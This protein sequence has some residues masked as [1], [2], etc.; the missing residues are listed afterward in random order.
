MKRE[1]FFDNAKFIVITLVVFGHVIQ[2]LTVDSTAMRTLYEWIYL[3]HMPAIILVSGFF[4]KGHYSWKYLWA[5][6]RK[7]LIPYLLFQKVYTSYFYFTTSAG[8]DTPMF[9]PH[10][11]LWF[12]LSLFSWHIL[13]IGFKHIPARF[14]IPLAFV[15]GILIGYVD[16]IGHTYSL[17]RT[18]VFFPFFLIGYWLTKDQLFLVKTTIAR[19][20]SLGL[21]VLA[22]VL[23][24]L[25]PEIPVGWL[26]G[27]S[28]YAALDVG[29][30]GGIIRVIQY[31]VML[32]MVFSLYAW[33][34][35]KQF[36]WTNLG[37]QTI[38]VYLLHGLFVQFF[39]QYEVLQ[40]NTFF[41]L[42]IIVAISLGIVLLLSSKPI[43]ISF[44]PIIETKTTAI[45]AH[46]EQINS[47]RA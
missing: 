22:F 26:F 18:F 35:R 11:S 7:L 23:V 3:F 15:M 38:Y 9:E 2:P 32:V 30:S 25:L 21:F 5:L 10:W 12:L 14:G 24:Y 8:W 19:R 29:L 44:Q 6:S 46:M 42:V 45:K 37:E 27:S 28:S 4:A 36:I 17:S 13:L 40:A 33:I 31:M 1:A 47:N 16:P 34:P 43:F 39:R 41:D 20:V